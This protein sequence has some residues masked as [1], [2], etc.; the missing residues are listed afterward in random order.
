[1]KNIKIIKGLNDAWKEI[2]DSK[3]ISSINFNN[4]MRFCEGEIES[5]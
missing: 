5:L 2:S 3:R 1:M 4:K